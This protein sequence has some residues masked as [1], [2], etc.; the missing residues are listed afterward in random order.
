MLPNP[1]FFADLVTL[2]ENFFHEVKPSIMS[3]PNFKTF[4]IF[5]SL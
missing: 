3:Q 1:Q 4:Q 5:P 2:T